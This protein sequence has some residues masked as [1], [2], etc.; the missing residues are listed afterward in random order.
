MSGENPEFSV[1]V[2]VFNERDNIAALV[3]RVSAAVTGRAPPDAVPPAPLSAR[4]KA[5][6]SSSSIGS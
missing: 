1:V 3:S 4:L 5:A 6:T 2:P